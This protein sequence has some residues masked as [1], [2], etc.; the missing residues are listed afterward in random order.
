MTLLEEIAFRQWLFWSALCSATG[1]MVLFAALACYRP[2]SWW[3]TALKALPLIALLVAGYANFAA[4]WVMAAL[5]FSLIGD[6]ALSR[7]GNRAFLIGLAGFLLAHLAYAVHFAAI[8]AGGI[9][10]VAWG[11]LGV[12]ALSTELWL[13]PFT[14]ALKWPVRAYVLAITAMGLLSFTLEGREI[15]TF[16]A[17][18]FLASDLILAL[19]LFRLRTPSKWQLPANISLWLLYGMAQIAILIGAGFTQPLFSF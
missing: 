10:L 14:G 8:G 17:L 3:K 15:A 19:Q 12:L 6:V 5:A 1:S 7:N 16:G 11:M 9:P 18:A 4:P 2:A 13:T